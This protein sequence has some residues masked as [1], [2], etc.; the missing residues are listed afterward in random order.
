M[1]NVGVSDL[2]SETKKFLDPVSLLAMRRDE[3]WAMGYIQT[4]IVSYLKF[5][6]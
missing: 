2:R 4:K 6:M 1:A 3:L 5:D